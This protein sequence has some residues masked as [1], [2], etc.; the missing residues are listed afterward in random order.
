MQEEVWLNHKILNQSLISQPCI[1]KHHLLLNVSDLLW[2]FL[3]WGKWLNKGRYCLF[4][5]RLP[6]KL[7]VWSQSRYQSISDAVVTAC[8][9]WGQKE[10]F[11]F[12][13]F[14]YDI[15][16]FFSFLTY[17]FFLLQTFWEQHGHFPEFKN[18]LSDA[19]RRVLSQ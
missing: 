12:F 11:F 3:I 1:H 2:L 8:P 4:L 18:Y 15:N 10:I 9:P 16:T 6:W 19:K 17:F 7:D 14:F 13:F 5:H